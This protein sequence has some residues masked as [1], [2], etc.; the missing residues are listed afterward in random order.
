MFLEREINK[1]YIYLMKDYTETKKAINNGY[2]E[3]FEWRV[4]VMNL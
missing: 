4:K 1:V 2:L 3:S